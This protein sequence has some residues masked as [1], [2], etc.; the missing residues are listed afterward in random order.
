MNPRARSVN[1]SISI[2]EPL[3]P[4]CA[5]PPETVWQRPMNSGAAPLALRPVY[6]CDGFTA[7]QGRLARPALLHTSGRLLGILLSAVGQGEGGLAHF[8]LRSLTTQP[9]RAAIP[10]AV[11]V[12]LALLLILLLLLRRRCHN[13]I[14][15]LGMLEIVLRC[16]PVTLR[17][18]I[19][20]Q[21]QVLFIDVRG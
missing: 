19:A 10:V 15:M 14:I 16:H 21:L 3:E 17:V 4:A 13:A 18:G 7:V 5:N 6:M 12:L 9:G 8:R 11:I 20:R 1:F 2:S